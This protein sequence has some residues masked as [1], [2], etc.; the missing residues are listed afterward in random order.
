MLPEVFRKT[1]SPLLSGWTLDPFTQLN[2]I[3]ALFDGEEPEF[4]ARL[5]VRETPN[6]FVIQADL[7]GF[8]KDDVDV[9]FQDGV[10]TLTGE[11]KREEK[12]EGE[13]FHFVERRVGRFARSIR[14]PDGLKP[15]TVDASLKDGVLTITVDKAEEIKPRKIAVKG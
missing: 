11:R 14:L 4:G 5:D 3:S 7:P 12:K 9:T 2:R 10:L 13:N 8:K 1:S 15:D 6:Q